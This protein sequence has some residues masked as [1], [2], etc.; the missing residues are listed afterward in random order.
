MLQYGRVAFNDPF[1]ALQR[2]NV[3]GR[4]LGAGAVCGTELRAL[5]ETQLSQLEHL[6]AQQRKAHQRIR[7][8][9]REAEKVNL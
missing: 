9:L 1:L 3:G 5:Q 4:V 6:I 8:V 2:D 7:H